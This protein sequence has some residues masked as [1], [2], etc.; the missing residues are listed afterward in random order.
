MSVRM[1]HTLRRLHRHVARQAAVA[2]IAALAAIQGAPSSV[3]ADAAAGSAAFEK[4]DYVRAQAEWASAAEHGDPDAEFGLGMLYERGDGNLKQDYKAARRWYE[5]AAAHGNIGA[6]Y[7]L[8]LDWSAGSDDV[9][10]DL[11]EAYKWIL[12]ASEKGLATD[13][14]AQLAQVLNRKQLAEAEKRAAAWKEA[15]AEP[16]P[17]A[18]P[19]ARAGASP[20][21][22]PQR[23]SGTAPTTTA[24]SGGC[25]GWPFP[26]LP[27]TEQFPALGGAPAQR[28]P[29]PSPARPSSPR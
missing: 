23:A 14:K 7:R 21:T 16:A 4:G 1:I 11:V 15:H 27:C 3:R 13:V 2:A 5:K 10:A 28:S 19:S 6:E 18:A 12:L 17:A 29:A 22:P 20:S 25:P 26:T 8:A 9:P 24:K